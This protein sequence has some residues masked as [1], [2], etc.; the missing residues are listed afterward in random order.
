[1]DFYA[2]P[3]FFVLLAIAII[4]A[5]I[6][7]ATERRIKPY[8]LAVSIVFI[9]LLFSRNLPGLAAL[10]ISLSIATA[11]TFSYQRLLRH[12]EH[13]AEPKKKGSAPP[14]AWP[15][16]LAIIAPLVCYKIGAVFNRDILGFIGISYITFKM[17][18][19]LLE[20]RDGVIPKIHLSDYLYF[21]LFFPPFTSG[22]IDRSR[23][24][25]SD[26]DAVPSSSQYLDL[27]G[28]GLLLILVG[29]L[30]KVVI[31]ALIFD[32]Y[33][34][35]PTRSTTPLLDAAIAFKNMYAYGLYLFFDFAGYSLMAM[36]AG[37]CFGI[38]VPRNFRAP[39]AAVDIKDFWN[40]WHIT[41]STWLR[42]FVFM[43]FTRLAIKR[44]WFSSRVTP[45]CMGYLLNM[46]LMGAWHGLTPS[47]LTY[48]FYHGILLAITEVYQRKSA[49]H[50][51]HRDKGWYRLASWAI[52][53]N[54]VFFGFAI[55]S[56]QVLGWLS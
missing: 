1:M 4:P 13:T 53:I 23:R 20:L 46:A 21:L 43:R 48:G 10:L 5:A 35:M 41:L 26:A 12:R 37:Y 17:V 14:P 42:D 51:R 52:T 24:F 7:G 36:G 38:R 11:A 44:R 33:S 40:R 34:W 32:F 55:F 25:G 50:K 39:F 9:V 49:F 8:G 2:Q 16:L 18:Q 45:A 27:L 31:S 28:K 19:V 47:Y 29:V 6:L 54:A 56:G 22:P 15:F 3:A 30:Y